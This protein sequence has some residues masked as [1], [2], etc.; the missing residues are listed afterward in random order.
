MR[1]EVTTKWPHLEP[2]EVPLYDVLK[3]AF[4]DTDQA[5]WYGVLFKLVH[6]GAVP[7]S[8]DAYTK[9]LAAVC[10]IGNAGGFPYDV[11][12]QM[13]PSKLDEVYKAVTGD[14]R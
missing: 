14:D 13:V 9:L 3:A 11:F 12:R 4:A 6:D 10:G 1:L 8:H 7:N 2:V 5:E